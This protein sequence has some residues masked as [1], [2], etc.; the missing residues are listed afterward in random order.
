M[1]VT[2]GVIVDG[3]AVTQR[4][5]GHQPRHPH[6]ARLV[7]LRRL[8]GQGRCSSTDD[9]LGNPVD[10]RHPWNQTTTPRPQK[11]ELRRQLHLGHVAALVRPADRR[12]P[13]AR[14]RRRADRP[15][16][17]HGPGRPGGHRLHQGDRP[18]RQDLPAQ[19]GDAARGRVRVEDPEVEQRHR[20]RTAPAPTSRPTPRPRHCTSPSR[21]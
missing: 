4:P 19:D 10:R 8:G 5:G 7:V 16:L 15:A 13:G 3:K 11:R 6:P 20:A 1:Y 2:P 18:Q 21:R 12:A 17:V 14:H 9:P